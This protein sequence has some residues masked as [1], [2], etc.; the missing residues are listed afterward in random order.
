MPDT[1]ETRLREL[2]LALRADPPEGHDARI[3]ARVRTEPPPEP[4]PAPAAWLRAR[5]R[6]VAALVGALLGVALVVSPVGAQVREWFGFHGVVVEERAPRATGEP[7]VPPATGTLTTE[8]AERLAGFAPVIP[9]ALGE[10]DRLAVSPDR[11]VVSMSWRTADGTLRLDQ[12][13]GALEP[14]FWKAS[15]DA[16]LVSAGGVD[17]LWF[18]T[19][20]DVVVLTDGGTRRYPPRLAAATLIWVRGEVTMRLEGDL[21]QEEAI[22]IATSVDGT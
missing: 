21:T 6:W 1:I 5:A 3:L 4:R 22:R 13:D 17:A 7:T 12:F 8:D 20:H 14:L 10:P 18:A 2:G 19:P 15:L 11:A 9:A 16:E